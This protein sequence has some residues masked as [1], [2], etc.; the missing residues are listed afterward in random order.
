[1]VLSIYNLNPSG[2]ESFQAA[3]L[4]SH[5]FREGTRIAIA[6]PYY[7]IALDGSKA[8]R[9]DSPSEVRILQGNPTQAKANMHSSPRSV[10]LLQKGLEATRRQ[11]RDNGPEAALDTAL[12]ALQD[13]QSESTVAACVLLNNRAQAELSSGHAAGALRDAEA[14]L[15]LCPTQQKAWMRYAASLRALQEPEIADR[16]DLVSGQALTR[17]GAPPD[18]HKAASRWELEVNLGNLSNLVWKAVNVAAPEGCENSLSGG[19]AAELKEKGNQQYV[20]GNYEVAV[21]FYTQGLLMLQ[22]LDQLAEILTI[23]AEAYL[24]CGNRHSA[25]ATAAASIRLVHVQ[26]ERHKATPLGAAIL[27][28]ALVALG[29]HDRCAD[30]LSNGTSFNRCMNA[31][32][33]KDVLRNANTLKELYSEQFSAPLSRSLCFYQNSFKTIHSLGE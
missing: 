4:L 16:A 30:M 27:A 5:R 21:K 28:K 12:E 14:V 11:L 22:G 2:K 17:V 32:D 24:A 23:I 18:A 19:T 9:V 6:E 31:A 7:K 8:V 15:A 20:S 10:K 3:P 33:K 13:P 25:A 1:M 29:E 26:G